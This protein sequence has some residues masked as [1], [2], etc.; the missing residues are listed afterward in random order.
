MDKLFARFANATAKATGSCTAGPYLCL[1]GNRF[2]AEVV[3]KNGAAA[4]PAQAVA[5]S[6][7]TG[8]Y[9][10]VDP[11]NVELVVK[12][13][14]GCA[15]NR[16]YW[17]FMGGLTNVR[18]EVTVTDVVTGAVKTYV[19]LDGHAFQPVQDISAFPSTSCL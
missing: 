18:V 19:N 4:A 5:I 10:F 16:Q 1:A 14:D 8:Y 2:R 12:V 15:I 11:A 7:D 6:G 9:W 17:V 3:W 13:L